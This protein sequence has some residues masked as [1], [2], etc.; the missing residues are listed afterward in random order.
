MPDYGNLPM[1]DEDGHL[2]VVVEAPKGSRTKLK[3]EPKL[4]AFVLDR[5]FQLGV[6]Y[7]YDWGFIPGTCAEDGDP[8]DAMVMFDAPTWPGVVIPIVPLGMVRVVQ[9]DAKGAELKRNDRIIARPADDDRWGDVKQIPKRVRDELEQFLLTAVE[10][11][12][13]RVTIEGWSGAKAALKAIEAAGRSHQRER[14]GA[15]AVR[16]ASVSRASPSR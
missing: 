6:A 2:L 16:R 4:Q 5:M 10:K 11:T 8:L 12:E 3:F 7:P 15:L 9:R 1:R 14:H 13:K